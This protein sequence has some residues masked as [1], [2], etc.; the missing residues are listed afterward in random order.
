MA[1]PVRL[2]PQL[3]R[4]PSLLP[5]LAHS[6]YQSLTRT[7]AMSTF[8]RALYTSAGEASSHTPAF[9]KGDRLKLIHKHDT[10][11]LEIEL[12]NGMRGYV[13]PAWVEELPM[14]PT[15][16]QEQQEQPP[17][18]PPAVPFGDLASPT[19]D[20]VPASEETEPEPAVAQRS[21]VLV[22][23]QSGSEGAENHGGFAPTPYTPPPEIVSDS[24]AEAVGDSEVSNRRSLEPGSPQPQD[25]YAPRENTATN[26]EDIKPIDIGREHMLSPRSAHASKRVSNE[27]SDALAA[28]IGIGPFAPQ[29]PHSQVQPGSSHAPSVADDHVDNMSKCS[30]KVDSLQEPDKRKPHRVAPPPPAAAKPLRPASAVVPLTTSPPKA[31]MRQNRRASAGSRPSSVGSRP[32]ATLANYPGPLKPKR[33][34]PPAGVKP[35]LTLTDEAGTEHASPEVEDSKVFD[36]TRERDQSARFRCDT[37]D[38]AQLRDASAR[39]LIAM[40]CEG[41]LERRTLLD[42]SKEVKTKSWKSYYVVLAGPT[43]YFFK[44]EAEKRKGKKPLMF[45]SIEDKEVAHSL[46]LT[47]KKY[48]FVVGNDQERCVAV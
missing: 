28:K 12:D 43:L 35:I 40:A 13:S 20:D 6:A 39:D 30:S 33:P 21:P 17:F 42:G 29:R 4:C 34:P 15:N 14:L 46:E 44:N 10:G 23:A 38:S 31:P 48:T 11:W 3:H 45:M 37:G 2:T 1:A 36:D 47:K 18:S 8:L 41:P 5:D 26:N 9:N 16:L 27:F 32:E 24:S 22:P 19:P 7:E 25:S